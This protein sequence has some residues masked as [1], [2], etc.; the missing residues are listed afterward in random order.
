[1]EYEVID[2]VTG[3]SIEPGDMI[4]LSD[5]MELYVTDIES[6]DGGYNVISKDGWDDEIITFIDE[7]EYVELLG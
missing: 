3:F 5:G 6:V 1:M 2:T 4:R 7:D